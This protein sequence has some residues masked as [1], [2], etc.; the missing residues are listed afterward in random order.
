MPPKDRLCPTYST[1]TPIGLAF[2]LASPA[3]LG[4]TYPITY[5]STPIGTPAILSTLNPRGYFTHTDLIHAHD[6]FISKITK[7]IPHK[8]FIN[9]TLWLL[10]Q[11]TIE[12]FPPALLHSFLLNKVKKGCTPLPALCEFFHTLYSE[13]IPLDYID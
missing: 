4:I 3:A 1:P 12:L 5:P 13:S 7:V 8:H 9:T 10:N 6:T 11:S 2:S